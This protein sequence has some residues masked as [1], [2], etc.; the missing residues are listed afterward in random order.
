M[1]HT[2]IVTTAVY[3]YVILSTNH[4]TVVDSA[5]RLSLHLKHL[6]A[7]VGITAYDI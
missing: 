3:P 2:I 5:N 1:L 6:G 4:K 7:I